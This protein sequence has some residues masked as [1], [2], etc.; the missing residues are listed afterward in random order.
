MRSMKGA[1]PVGL[2]LA[3]T[4]LCTPT[5]HAAVSPVSGGDSTDGWVAPANVLLA[6]N[7]GD[8][9]SDEVVQGVTFKAWSLGD[10]STAPSYTAGITV[11]TNR[12][13]ASNYTATPTGYGGGVGNDANMSAMMERIF[14]NNDSGG[15]GPLTFTITGLSPGTYRVDAF[16]YSDGLSNRTNERFAIN[17]TTT[18]TF[19]EVNASYLV[20]NTVTIAGN[21]IQLDVSNLAGGTPIL[22]GIVVSEVPEP[23]SLAVVGITTM[24]GC[25]LRRRRAERTMA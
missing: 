3:V 14:Y 5:S 8:T 22:S 12:S 13:G 21:S 25:A 6:Y 19:N 20:Q 1:I 18:D 16:T 24:G 11:T 10:G 23:S 15:V 4:F 2:L 17:G 9:V 7:V